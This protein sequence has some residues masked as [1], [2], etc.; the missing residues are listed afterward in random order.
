MQLPSRKRIAAYLL[1]VTA[2]FFCTTHCYKAVRRA[3]P[4]EH[5]PVDRV[6]GAAS[7]GSTVGFFLHLYFPAKITVPH[8]A[9]D[10]R[11]FHKQRP[12]FLAEVLSVPSRGYCNPRLHPVLPAFAPPGARRQATGPTCDQI[13]HANLSAV[14]TLVD[15]SFLVGQQ[16]IVCMDLPQ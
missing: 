5:I 14:L 3:S 6:Q 9:C 15:V 10:A 7:S 4:P 11:R 13:A 12:L 16:R 8:S 2:Q 1:A